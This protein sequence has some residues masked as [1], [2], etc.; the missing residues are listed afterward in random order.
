MSNNLPN[1]EIRR[2]LIS[3][4]ELSE[5]LNCSLRH[6]LNMDSTGRIPRPIRLG[7]LVR[8]RIDDIN[9]WLESGAPSREEWERD[10]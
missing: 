1:R 2:I 9:A 6:V 4:R 3:A 8:W 5:L 7:K 10:K